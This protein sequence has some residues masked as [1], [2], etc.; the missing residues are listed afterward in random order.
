METLQKFKIL[1]TQCAVAGSPTRSPNTSPGFQLRRRKTL[2]MLLIRSES[3]RLDSSVLERDQQLIDPDKAEKKRLLSHTLKDLL[4]STPPFEGKSGEV[5]RNG[6]GK[7]DRFLPV[8]MN[9]AGS[10]YARP[11]TARL[12]YRLLRRAWRPMLVTIPE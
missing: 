3:S 10:G 12:R 2:R 5:T 4:V 6:G 8:V 11:I 9:R 1:A 7:R